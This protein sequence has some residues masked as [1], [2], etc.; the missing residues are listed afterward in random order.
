[1]AMGDDLLAILHE[2]IEFRAEEL[3]ERP[4]ACPH[5]GTP[6][7]ENDDGVLNCPMGDYRTAD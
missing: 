6:L 7:V 4:V 3:T 2:N 1:M 5:D